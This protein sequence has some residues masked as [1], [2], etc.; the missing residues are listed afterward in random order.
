MRQAEDLGALGVGQRA[1]L[2]APPGCI[3]LL[4]RRGLVQP[5]LPDPFQRARHQTVLRFHRVALPPRPFGL[6][7]RPIA[8]EAPQ[9]VQRL[10][11]RLDLPH[12]CDRQ[13]DLVRRR[14]LQQHAFELGIRA[15]RPDLL[16]LRLARG[17]L[18]G[19]AVVDGVG[20]LRP[21]AAHAHAPA[22]VA[23]D[24]DPLQQGA[25]DWP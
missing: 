23:A 10:G 12:G 22:A 20:A 2:L 1:R 8:F 24:G 21:G 6:V 25:P 17:A 15:Q 7:A 13:Y 16:A 9:V 14:G 11:L 3:G 18:V 5:P 4:D 19:A